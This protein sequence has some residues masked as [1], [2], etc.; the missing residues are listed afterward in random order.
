MAEAAADAEPGSPRSPT[1]LSDTDRSPTAIW[2]P[3]HGQPQ[4]LGGRVETLHLVD[5]TSGDLFGLWE[6]TCSKLQKLVLLNLP[7]VAPGRTV[8]LVTEFLPRTPELVELQLDF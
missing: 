8:S 3:T 1:A 7:S 2:S 6:L 5:A 4:G